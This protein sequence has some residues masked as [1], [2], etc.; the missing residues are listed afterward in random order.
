MKIIDTTTFYNENLMMDVRFNILNNYVDY[1]VVCEAK[2]SHSGKKKE[3]NFKI[4]NFSEFKKKIIYL[5]VENEPSNLINGNEDIATMRMNS[6]KRIGHQRD[7]IKN[8][9]TNFS[10]DDLI[11]YSDNDEIPKLD[12]SLIDDKTDLILFKQKIYYYKFNLILPNIDWFGTK[13][14]RVKSFKDTTW[15]RNI[16]N[17]KYS[18]LRLDTIFSKSKYQN[19]KIITNGGWHFSN[20]KSVTDLHDKYL[21]D[22]NHAVFDKMMNIDE[23]EKNVKNWEIGIDHTQDKKSSKLFTK[24]K[25]QKDELSKLP[26]YIVNNQ[27]KFK[28]WIIK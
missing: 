3:L 22:E 14:C 17:K 26:S 12:Q 2:Y 25:L 27:I 15:L 9:L 1:F 16:K 10:N 6:I 20:L 19:I 11:L 7:Y 8:C 24:V 28:D 18:S 23:I 5:I 13:G 4:N 21:N